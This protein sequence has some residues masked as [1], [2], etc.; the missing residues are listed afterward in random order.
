MAVRVDAG[1]RSGA[2][3]WNA[4]RPFEAHEA[5]EAAWRGASDPGERAVYQGLVQY[6][7]AWVKLRAGNLRGFASNASK[8]ARNLAGLERLGDEA[9]V[10]WRGA[11]LVWV[12]TPGD[13]PP[14]LPPAD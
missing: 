7:A 2:A 9:L 8:A 11:M 4:G 12:R 1:Y 13:A 3:E 6:A 5:F 14:P 10:A